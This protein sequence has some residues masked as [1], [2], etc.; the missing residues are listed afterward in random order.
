MYIDIKKKEF[1]LSLINRLINEGDIDLKTRLKEGS[2]NNWS[3]I[4][5]SR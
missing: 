5:K 3:N 4:Q 2:I 1:E